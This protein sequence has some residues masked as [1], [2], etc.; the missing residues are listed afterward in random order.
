MILSIQQQ[1]LLIKLHQ[2][3][4]STQAYQAGHINSKVSAITKFFNDVG[5]VELDDA[6]EHLTITDAAETALIEN[7]L[8]DEFGTLTDAA[9][10]LLNDPI[11]ESTTPKLAT[12][13]ALQRR[14]S[15][16]PNNS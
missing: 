9:N 15:F 5:L 1:S 6:A 13:F 7:G 4:T 11:H 14:N 16:L 10:D 8:L 3:G 2:L 12:V